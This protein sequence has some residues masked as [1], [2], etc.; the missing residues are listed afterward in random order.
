[1]SKIDNL[2]PSGCPIAYLLDLVGDRW[3]LLI[4]REIMLNKVNTYGGMLQADEGIASNILVDRLKTLTA[5]GILTK[6]R[7][8]DNRRSF[9]Y[10]LTEK[11]RDLAPILIEMI[12]WSGQHDPRPDALKDVV[13]RARADRDALEAG[14]RGAGT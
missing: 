11:G 6:T 2:R 7:D 12:L 9:I 5:A 3:S 8:P 1:M 14:M 13:E 4:I 10:A